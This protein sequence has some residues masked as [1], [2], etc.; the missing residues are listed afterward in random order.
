MSEK[1]APL[2]RSMPLRLALALVVL[3]SVISLISLA[4]SFLVTQ[5]SFEQAMRA[6][7]TQRMAGFRAA[8]N[9]TAVAALVKAEARETDPERMVLSYLAPN[10]SHFGNAAIARDD[11]GYHI[12]SLDQDSPDLKGRYL[13]FTAV[14]HGGRLT[15]ARSRAEIE[16]LRGVFLNILGLSLVPTILIALSGGLYLARRSA[17]NVDAI[18]GTLDRLTNGDL[19][20][21]VGA[22]QG[23]SG[24]LADIAD[25]ID[26]MA[27][28]QET[29]VTAIR[30]VSS[31]IAHDLKT[32]IQ[33]V[34]VHLQDLS[35][36]SDLR[37]DARRHLESAQT[38]LE[39]VVSVFGSLLQIAQIESGSPKSGF[40]PVD[41]AELLRICADLYGPA[42]SE[43]GHEL[44]TEIPPD[45]PPVSGDRNLLMQLLANLVE[46]ALRHTPAGTR[47]LLSL[48][49][50][51]DSVVLG[52]SD[53]GPGIPRAETDNVLQRL[54]RLDQSRGTPGSG[55]GL[56]F[57]SVVARLHDAALHLDDNAPGLRVSLTFKPAQGL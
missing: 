33:R 11:E 38:E 1:L 9:A 56:N 40:A 31:D 24:D 46:N 14:L 19:Q 27:R 25:R 10:R 26:Q 22:V 48:A 53:T 18:A 12:V 39:A 44:A 30:Q 45:V 13:A 16:A 42:A 37:P 55:L 15:I 3:F 23:W 7:L 54:Y 51:D 57:V 49:A 50:R 5:R 43:T 8:P 28:A 6:D 47:I 35:D 36:S 21:R 29:S 52:V 34:A 32:P 17:R 2:L 4:A 20:A 41:L